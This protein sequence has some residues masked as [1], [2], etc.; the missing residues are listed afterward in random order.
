MP[1]SSLRFRVPGGQPGLGIRHVSRGLLPR[2]LQRRLEAAS[3]Q[4]RQSP[5]RRQIIQVD[6][7]VNPDQQNML[8]ILDR[9]QD[10]IRP[11]P[12]EMQV[13]H[14]LGRQKPIGGRGAPIVRTKITADADQSDDGGVI[15]PLTIGKRDRQNEFV[16]AE[17]GF[18]LPFNL[19][20]IER[21]PYGC[22]RSVRHSLH[23]AAGQQSVRPVKGSLCLYQISELSRPQHDPGSPA[24]AVSGPAPPS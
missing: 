10:R 23:D 13:K 5:S 3:S 24:P 1:R 17:D 15:P 18:G 21:L 4:H 11:G 9:V 14:F 19:G 16:V 12:S 22:P 6:V 7:S 8:R 20:E 2:G